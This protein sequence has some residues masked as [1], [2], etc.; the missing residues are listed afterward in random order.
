MPQ[1]NP[2]AAEALDQDVE[3]VFHGVT[4]SIPPTTRWPFEA[5]EA[6]EDGKVAKF[7]TTLLGDA[8][9]AAWRA[10]KPT[11]ADLGEFVTTIQGALGIRGN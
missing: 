2:T 5:I 10:L 8:Q 7:L 11:V 3:V 6:Y 1:T 4:F 9:A